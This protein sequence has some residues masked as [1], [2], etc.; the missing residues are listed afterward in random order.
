[1][2]Q[3]EALEAPELAGYGAEYE[4]DARAIA[5]DEMWNATR[6]KMK[7]DQFEVQNQQSY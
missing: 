2:E 1:M 7:D 4:E 3:A 6:K 5:D